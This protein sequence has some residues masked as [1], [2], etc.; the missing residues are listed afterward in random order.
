MENRRLVSRS[1]SSKKFK[2]KGNDDPIS[3]EEPQ[4][5]RTCTNDVTSAGDDKF[6]I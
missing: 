1:R 4:Q 6:A 5:L 2:A 3:R